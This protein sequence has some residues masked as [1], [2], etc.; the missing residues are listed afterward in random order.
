MITAS[1]ANLALKTKNPRRIAAGIING[2]KRRPWDKQDIQRLREQCLQRRPWLKSTGPRTDEGKYR[3]RANGYGHLP[4]PKS[5]RQIWAS[6]AD[7]NGMMA[8]MAELRRSII[9]Q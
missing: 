6:L 9:G 3:S 5:L 1:E 8:Q 4:D 2:S 7:V